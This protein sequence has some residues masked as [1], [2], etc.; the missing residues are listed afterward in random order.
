MGK[1]RI[2]VLGSRLYPIMR[3]LSS[4]WSGGVICRRWERKTRFVDLPP[5]FMLQTQQAPTCKYGLSYKTQHMLSMNV[6]PPVQMSCGCPI[7]GALTSLHVFVTKLRSAATRAELFKIKRK[8][9]R[10]FTIT[11]ESQLS[12]WSSRTSATCICFSGVHMRSCLFHSQQ[13]IK[14]G[15]ASSFVFEF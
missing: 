14:P 2:C 7:S 4:L 6:L 15:S 12:L 8:A 3:D 11:A 13:N 1:L 5:V 9:A 10:A